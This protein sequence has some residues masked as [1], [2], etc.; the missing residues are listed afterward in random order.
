MCHGRDTARRFLPGTAAARHRRSDERH[1]ARESREGGALF[2]GGLG[3]PP[4]QPLSAPLPA[5]EVG[6]RPERGRAHSRGPL[7]N[8]NW[9]RPQGDAPAPAESP[10]KVQPRRGLRGTPPNPRPLPAR[11]GRSKAPTKRRAPSGGRVQ[12]GRSP[13]WWGLGGTP[14][15]LSAPL[16][17]REVGGRLEWRRAYPDA[18]SGRLYGTGTGTA[19]R[20]RCP[21]RWE[22]PERAEPSLVGAWGTP[23]PFPLRFPPG[24][25][26]DVRSGEGRSS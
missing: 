19:P 3:V 13:L 24:K 9:S 16:P 11:G 6:R 14:Q 4:P 8:G 2:G 18:E 10:E 7:R 20:A 5:K 15:P 25:W 26:A 21:L 1:P 12:R 17:A 23:N 22:S